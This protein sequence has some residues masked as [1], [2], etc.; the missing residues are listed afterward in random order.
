RALRDLA[1]GQARLLDGG[2]QEGGG[3]ALGHVMLSSVVS[4]T[5]DIEGRVRSGRGQGRMTEQRDEK[6]K[7]CSAMAKA[8]S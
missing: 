6:V 4:F 1:L 3:G 5:A 8:C 7:S 2:G